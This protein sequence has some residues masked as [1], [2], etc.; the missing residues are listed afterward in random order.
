MKG[1]TDEIKRLR[2]ENRRLKEALKVSA[3]CLPAAVGTGSLKHARSVGGYTRT[4]N[5]YHRFRVHW[6]LIRDCKPE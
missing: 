6:N 4:T 5:S 2:E 1:E 3:S